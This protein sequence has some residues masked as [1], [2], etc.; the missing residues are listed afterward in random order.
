[1]TA[2][3]TAEVVAAWRDRAEHPPEVFIWVYSGRQGGVPCVGNTRVPVESVVGSVLADG[4]V[5]GAMDA[6]EL[7][8]PEVLVSCMFEADYP[9]GSDLLDA[10]TRSS[11]V[12]WAYEFHPEQAA[13]AWDLIPDPPPPT[14]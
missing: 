5:A 1:M 2:P 12:G 9:S 8:R 13:R 10:K 4:G 3:L 7:S 11:W 6:Y 14:V